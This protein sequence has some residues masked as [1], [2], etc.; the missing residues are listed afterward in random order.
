M[1]QHNPQIPGQKAA[2]QPP[3]WEPEGGRMARIFVAIIRRYRDKRPP[4]SPR[5]GSQRAAMCLTII[6]RY[7]DKRPPS[8]PD[9]EPEG[10]QTACVVVKFAICH[11]VRSRQ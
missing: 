9:M 2:L 3:I 6:R 4:S 7:R 5:Y 1:R 8:S 11:G 10:G